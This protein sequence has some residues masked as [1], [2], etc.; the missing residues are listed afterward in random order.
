MSAHDTPRS[1]PSVDYTLRKA[2][3]VA[4]CDL[5]R[6]RL[7]FTLREIRSVASAP[8]RVQ[9]TAWAAPVA[10]TLLSFALPSLGVQRVRGIVQLLSMALTGYRIFQ[11]WQAMQQPNRP[12][13]A[14]FDTK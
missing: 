1:T 6:L 5:E 4:Q 13:S 2:Q 7:Q 14:G 9:P 8:V 10:A 3:L 12:P 11:N